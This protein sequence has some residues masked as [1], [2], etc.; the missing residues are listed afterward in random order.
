MK[1]T[2]TN[3]EGLV[4]IEPKVFLDDRGYFFE[5]F[6]QKTFN[7]AIGRETRFVQDNES[8]STKGVLRGLHYQTPPFSQGKLVRVVHGEV[9]DVAVDI[10]SNSPS[11]AVN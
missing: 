6:N 2:N 8:Y 5:S 11:F 9:F 1:I 3:I 10:R 7:D 4:I